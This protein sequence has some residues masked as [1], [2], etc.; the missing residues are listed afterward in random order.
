M[1]HF[2]RKCSPVPNREKIVHAGGCGWS[3]LREMG[4]RMTPWGTETQET[5][6]D[7]QGS[8]P[9]LCRYPHK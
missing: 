7:P 1:T 9:L 3:P 2:R 8:R 4:V 5:E 6:L